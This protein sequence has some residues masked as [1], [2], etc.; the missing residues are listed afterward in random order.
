VSHNSFSSQ[1]VKHLATGVLACPSMHT[2]ALDGNRLGSSGTITVLSTLLVS[3]H[4]TL[5][6]LQQVSCL[7]CQSMR[8]SLLD[9]RITAAREIPACLSRATAVLDSPPAASGAKPVRNAM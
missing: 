8:Y 4:L 6:S 9:A 1:A 7:T 2:L 5:L 3:E